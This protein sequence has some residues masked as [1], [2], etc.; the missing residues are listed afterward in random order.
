M[1]IPL[2][3][4]LKLGAYL[5]RQQLARRK[6]FPLIVELEP[7]FACNLECAG[8]GKIQHP[9]EVLRQR[10]SVEDA[11]GAME[12]S[13]AP[14]VSIA[15]GEPLLHPEIGRMVS[16]LVRRKRFVYLCTNAI[17][18]KRKIDQ[19]TPSPYFSFVIHV[20]GLRER[21]DELVCRDGVFDECVEAIRLAK[22]RGFRVTTN[23]TFFN[24]DSP[25]TVREVLDFLNDDLEVD[26]MM[27]SPGYAYEKAPDQ[28]HFLGVQQTQ[29]LF[30]DSFADGRRKKWRLN[31]TPLFLDFLE[32]KQDY[33]CTA[34]G[35]PSYSVF[36]WQRPCYLMADG[37][38]KTYRELVDT[39]DWSK[40][41]RGRDPRC[42]NCMAHCGYEPT[43]V[44]ATTKSL[45]ES[46]R[47]AVTTR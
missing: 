42:A 38:A 40:Y 20:D 29:R 3:Q 15:G 9:T 46:L 34:W 45:K 32:G 41:G 28:V 11:V 6:Q 44:I 7:L 17:L 37:Y 47:A 33:E 35:I 24:T 19:F 14:M 31:H 18:L 39:T 2:R 27:V 5:A 4:R 8:C 25:K 13:G 26:G 10:V 22:A 43:A 21:H 36:G 30:R 16:E 23:S 12:E 1:A